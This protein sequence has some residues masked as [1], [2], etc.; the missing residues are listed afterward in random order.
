MG[1]Y[2]VRI[3][4]LHDPAKVDALHEVVDVRVPDIV[5]EDEESLLD[6]LRLRQRYDQVSEISEPRV[7]LDDYD[8]SV[9][10][11]RPERLFVVHFLF[12]IRPLDLTP[13]FRY[14]EFRERA[15]GHIRQAGGRIATLLQE[16]ENAG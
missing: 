9:A 15:G 6:V 1:L 2:T 11:Q 5:A 14:L 3:K 10:G 13:D 8:R 4:D 12:R 7:H 16:S